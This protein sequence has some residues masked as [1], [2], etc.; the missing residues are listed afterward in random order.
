[1][2]LSLKPLRNQVI[3]ITGASSGIGLVTARMAAKQ[4]AKVVLAARNE[5]ALRQLSEEIRNQD[6]HATYVVADVGKEEDVNRIAQRATS[7]FGDF[8][9]WVNNAGISIL[10][11]LYGIYNSRHEA[12]VRYRLL[13]SRLRFSR[14]RQ[15]LSAAWQCWG[16]N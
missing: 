2:A 11:S 9:T 10:W 3:V 16:A 1:M 7:E 14:R 6:G 13:G 4:G 12:D 15:S 5:D 8:D